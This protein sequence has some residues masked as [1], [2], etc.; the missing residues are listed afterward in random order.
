[1]IKKNCYFCFENRDMG[2][3]WSACDFNNTDYNEKTNPKFWSLGEHDCDECEHY[4]TEGRLNELIVEKLGCT[5]R[6]FAMQNGQKK[7]N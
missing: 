2:A 7:E 4:I 3:A 1:M 6:E 5:I